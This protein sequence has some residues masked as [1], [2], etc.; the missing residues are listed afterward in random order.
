MDKLNKV[1][2]TK[3]ANCFLHRLIKLVDFNM[4]LFRQ[5]R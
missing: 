3:F 4:T 5:M 2:E 1:S